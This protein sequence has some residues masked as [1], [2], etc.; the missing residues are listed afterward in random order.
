ML[1]DKPNDCYVASFLSAYKNS[2][3]SAVKTT[4]LLVV[5]F[6]VVRRLPCEDPGSA[7]PA[8]S[9]VREQN[10]VPNPYQSIRSVYQSG[11]AVVIA[12]RMARASWV[13]LKS[14]QS[15]D[16]E[17]WKCSQIGCNCDWRH[18]VMFCPALEEVRRRTV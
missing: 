13:M 7:T 6:T 1:S 14:I 10:R 9:L 4:A 12:S 5:T 2:C 18:T 11:L 17:M 16:M 15:G 8:V 3:S